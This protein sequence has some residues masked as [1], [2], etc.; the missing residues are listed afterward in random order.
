MTDTPIFVNSKLY[1]LTLENGKFYVGKTTD[2]NTIFSQH[3]NGIAYTR[4]N[5]ILHITILPENISA[6][7]EDCV[8]LAFMSQL[9]IDNVRGGKYSSIIFS[10]TELKNIIEDLNKP[11]PVY[12]NLTE[13]FYFV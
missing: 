8:I 2:P 1:I 3:I 4:L 9:G 12:P 10:E 7:Y 5:K 13:Y 6:I 11:N